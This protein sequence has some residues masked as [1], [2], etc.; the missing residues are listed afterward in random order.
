VTLTLPKSTLGTVTLDSAGHATFTISTLPSGSNTI[1]AT[2]SGDGNFL[3]SSGRTVQTV[4]A[5]TA[6]ATTLVSS[7]N[8]A[9]F[10]TPVTFTATVTGAGNGPT[11]TVSFIDAKFTLASVTLNSSGVATFTTSSLS[12]G[13]HNMHAQY[14]GS[15]QYNTS[16]SNVVSQTVS[17]ATTSTILASQVAPSRQ[18]ASVSLVSQ[19]LVAAMQTVVG[20]SQQ[21]EGSTGAVTPHRIAQLVDRAITD[22][23]AEKPMSSDDKSET[24]NTAA[25]D[26]IFSMI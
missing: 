14:N 19:G 15:S 7:I 12:I 1:T 3:S 17:A 11:G 21:K 24:L 26:T 6:T 13:T 18:S 10:G 2:Y 8:P 23:A 9:V 25:L 22:L 20:A 4:G 16:S 5:K